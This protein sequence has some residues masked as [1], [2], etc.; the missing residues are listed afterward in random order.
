MR[1]TLIVILDIRD[2]HA[3]Q[4]PFIPQEQPIKTLFAYGPNPSLSEG[5]GV[6]CLKRSVNN[7]DALCCEDRIEGAGEF[8]VMVVNEIPDGQTRL[9]E[10]PEQ[11][12][13]LLCHPS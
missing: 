2:E 3:P 6:W 7:L 10:F 13:G 5:D 11:L 4:M 12:P 9:I 1:A 8:R